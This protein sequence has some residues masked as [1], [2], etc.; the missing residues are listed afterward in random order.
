MATKFTKLVTEFP[1]AAA[2]KIEI[3]TDDGNYLVQNTAIQIT[4][5]NTNNAIIIKNIKG[6]TPYVIL[7]DEHIVGFRFK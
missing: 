4:E 6:T 3:I 5:D 7:F 1:E 2:A